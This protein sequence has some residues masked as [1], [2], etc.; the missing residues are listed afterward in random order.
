MVLILKSR[1]LL[2]VLTNLDK[3]KHKQL[4]QE[5]LIKDLIV[6]DLV[7]YLFT[8]KGETFLFTGGTSLVKQGI[9]KRFSEDIDLIRW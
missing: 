6:T 3:L 4:D 5:F 7:D 9:I 1:R 8:Q 2:I